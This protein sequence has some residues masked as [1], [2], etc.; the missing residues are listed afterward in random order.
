MSNQT[1]SKLDQPEI[2]AAIFHPQTELRNQTP[3]SCEEFE[4]SVASDVT[5]GC[6][7]FI[8]QPDAPTIIFF[9]G[10]GET[11]SDYDPIAPFY[12]KA[13]LNILISGYRGYGWS[14]GE[15]TVSA[16]YHD[17]TV[18]LDKVLEHCQLNGFSEEVFIMGRSL[19]SASCIDLAYRF[20]E[21]IKGIIID[22]GFAE[23]LPLAARLGYNVID[24]GLREEDC[25]NNLAKIREIEIPTLILHGADDQLIPLHEAVK[26]QAESGAKTKQLF[27]IPGADHNSLLVRG[28]ETYFETIKNF[29]DTVTG[30]N[31]WRQRRRK[32][33]SQENKK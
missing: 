32:F 11:V 8:T 25:F 19:G 4:I 31:T 9:H 5:L 28:G 18:V 23:T 27:V 29:T 2:L 17:G 10:N 7:L 33:K 26:L 3:S 15:P 24:S 6:R 21:R 22:S 20:P 13:G 12:L 14:S 1:S 30:R 16:L